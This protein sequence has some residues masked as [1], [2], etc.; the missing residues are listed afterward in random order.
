[1]AAASGCVSI[2]AAMLGNLPYPLED[3]LAE[4]RAYRLAVTMAHQ[5]L[6]QLPPDLR[7]EAEKWQRPSGAT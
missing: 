1:M 7:A 6:A 3:M 4:A 5:N 2:L